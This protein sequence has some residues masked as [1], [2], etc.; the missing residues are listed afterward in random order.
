M[1]RSRWLP[2][3][4]A[5]LLTTGGQVFGDPTA[6]GDPPPKPKR[7]WVLALGGGVTLSAGNTTGKQFT[8][9]GKFAIRGRHIEYLT[10]LDLLYGMSANARTANRGRWTQKVANPQKK[11]INP[12]GSLAFEYDE[13]ASIGLRANVG[14]GAQWVFSDREEN[15]SRVVASMNGETVDTTHGLPDRKSFRLSIEYSK[16]FRFSKTSRISLS[17]LWTPN[18]ADFARDYRID[19]NATLSVMMTD[20]LWLT[21]KLQNRFNNYPPGAALKK[22][23]LT[24]VTAIEFSI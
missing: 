18:L 10:T 13:F 19:A 7:S 3:V 17:S 21:L 9:S 4:L 8:H 16:E 23:D 20:P 2:Q 24:L 1:V 5:L 22:N 12:F 14:L 11:R 6:A 15:R